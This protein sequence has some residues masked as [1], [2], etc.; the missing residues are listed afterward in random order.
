MK[1]RVMPTL[2]NQEMT[3]HQRSQSRSVVI[4]NEK[5]NLCV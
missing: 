3:W 5:K 4:R 2:R 1:K